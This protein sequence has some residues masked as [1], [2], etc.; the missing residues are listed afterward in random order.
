LKS[1]RAHVLI[2]G[3]VQ[4]VSFRS[5]IKRMAISLDLKGWVRNLGDD[6]VEAL[7]EGPEDKVKEMLDWCKRGPP[8]SR[9]ENIETEINNYIG[10]FESFEVIL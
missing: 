1:V 3:L 5:S 7:F 10:E 2:T 9:V 6:K 8:S 4:G